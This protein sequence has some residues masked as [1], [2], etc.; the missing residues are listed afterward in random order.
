M[1]Y[2]EESEYPLPCLAYGVMWARAS[3]ITVEL[4]R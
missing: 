2:L 3:A 4:N 1:L